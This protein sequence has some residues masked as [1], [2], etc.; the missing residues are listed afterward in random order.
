MDRLRVVVVAF[1]V[2]VTAVPVYIVLAAPSSSALAGPPL[3]Y[4]LPWSGVWGSP[5]SA[6]NT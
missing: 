4:Y 5:R 3:N 6:S 2:A 1:M